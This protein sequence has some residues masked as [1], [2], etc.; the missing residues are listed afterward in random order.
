[1]KKHIIKTSVFIACLL[2]LTVSLSYSFYTY[3]V[4]TIGDKDTTN[5]AMGKIDLDFQTSQ[6]FNNPQMML[7]KDEE[8]ELKADHT[9]FTVGHTE[10]STMDLFYFVSLTDITISENFKSPDFKWSLMKNGEVAASGNFANIGS[11]TSMLLTEEPILLSL[12]STDT[13]ILRVW[14][15][16]TD[17]DQSALYNGNFSGK[18]EVSARV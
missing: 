4:T 7:I 14:L 16:E 3:Q 5:V 18:V 11:E 17:Q 15:S 6:Y 2:V 1:M 9:D 8:A 10:E 12:G 13:L